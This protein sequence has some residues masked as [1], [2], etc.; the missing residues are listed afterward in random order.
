VEAPA[1]VLVL[2]PPGV[3]PDELGEVAAA[4]D[5]GVGGL[6]V[7]PRV[8]DRAAAHG[9][10]GPLR[11]LAR[12]RAELLIDG[13]LAL[14]AE[15]GC[16]L[17]LAEGGVATAQ[18]R[19]RLGPGA[20]LGRVVTSAAAATAATGADFLAVEI[21]GTG[22]GRARP[23]VDGAGLRRIVEA[24][25]EPVLVAGDFDRVEAADAMAVGA[26][27]L[28]VG[29][30]TWRREPGLVAVVARHPVELPSR[31]PGIRSGPAAI[32]N[33]VIVVNGR[34]ITTDG[35]TTLADLAAEAGWSAGSVVV[36]LNG[37]RIA[38]RRLGEVVPH[39]GDQVTIVGVEAGG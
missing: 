14:A 34:E 5:A 25:W 15:A 9:L 24:S 18:A 36:S 39:P 6:L 22:L 33:V 38:R 7:R 23:G 37:E 16:G 10:L 11:G 8:G 30:S 29:W 21:G 17:L 13:D 35:D 3:T 2:E 20:L 12:G 27:G 26:H 1:L 31:E 32:G 4:V 19:R 28:I